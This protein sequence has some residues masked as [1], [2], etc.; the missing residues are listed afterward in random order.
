M[1]IVAKQS[2]ISFN[3]GANAITPA[4]Q[5]FPAP[6]PAKVLKR[7]PDLKKWQEENAKRWE[8]ICYALK[9][10]RTGENEYGDY[11]AEAGDATLEGVGGVSN[12]DSKTL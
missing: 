2:G 10:R 6:L 7:F 5:P 3:G 11:V 12:S 4:V 1:A 8:L 9:L